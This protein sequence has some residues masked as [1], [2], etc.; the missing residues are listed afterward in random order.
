LA[1]AP[2]VK[3]SLP[4]VMSAIA[5]TW[6]A[7]TDKTVSVVQGGSHTFA[8]SDFGFSDPND[9]PANTLLAVRITTLPAVGT[10]RLNGTNVTAGQVIAAGSIGTLVYTPAANA[11]GSN[12][13]SFTFQVQDNGGTANGGVDL[14]Q[15]ANTITV[16]VTTFNFAP[17]GADKTITTNEASTYTFATSDFGFTDP[18]NSPPNNLLA[19]RIATLPTIGSL[20]L[21]GANVTAGQFVAAAD[22]TAGKLGY[23]PAANASGSNYASFTFQVQDDGGTAGGGVDLDQS[24]NTI[25]V[26]V[27]AINDAPA[28]ADKSVTI[29]EDASYTFAASDFGFTDPNDTPANAFAAVKITTLPAAG[30]L[31]LNNVA[32]VAGD[33]IAVASIGNENSQRTLP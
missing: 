22:I 25:T 18:S 3:T 7:G 21:N 10:L 15:S 12:Y 14:D 26:N 11:S 20:T 19:V 31:R 32:V 16:N 24:A 8:A 29:N 28:G 27:T 6:P 1:F 9:V 4:A 33:T 2:G 30:T 23:T 5:T 13:A 17:A